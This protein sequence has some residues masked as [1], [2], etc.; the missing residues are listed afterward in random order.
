MWQPCP[1]SWIERMPRNNTPGWLP[2][3]ITASFLVAVAAGIKS[4]WKLSGGDQPKAPPG[5]PRQAGVLQDWG[6]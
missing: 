2:Y 6:L 4:G 1:S 3:A 5:P